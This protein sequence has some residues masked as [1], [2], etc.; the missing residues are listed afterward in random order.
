MK[1]IFTDN[2]IFSHDKFLFIQRINISLRVRFKKYYFISFKSKYYAPEFFHHMRLLGHSV[3]IMIVPCPSSHQ[4]SGN[5]KAT[6]AIT[7]CGKGG[8]DMETDLG[9]GWSFP[10]K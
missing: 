9:G 8:L 6:S 3:S 7:K 2:K 5:N 10:S 4:T 1:D